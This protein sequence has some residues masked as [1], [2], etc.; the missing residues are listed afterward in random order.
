MAVNPKLCR[1][2][3][4]P[5]Q[6]VSDRILKSMGRRGTGSDVRELLDRIRE[7]IPDII[8]RTSLIVGFPDE[9]EDDFETLVKFVEKYRFDR[10][11]VF[12]YSR[13]EGTP[14]ADMKH[15]IPEKVKKQRH[16][17]IMALQQDI[18]A[19][20]NRQRLGKVYRVL[21]EGVSEDGIFYYGRS[22]AEAPDIDGSIYFTSMEPLETGCLVNVK[23]LNYENYDLI[24][25][26]ENESA[27]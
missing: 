27:E 13:E 1:Y 21:V 15:Q 18:A 3:D 10:L 19:E 6:H 9:T 22:F 16:D 5:I 11:G 8:L 25:E 2:L 7:R 12:M 20:K 14:A 4:I 23:I 24:G 17:T 26:V